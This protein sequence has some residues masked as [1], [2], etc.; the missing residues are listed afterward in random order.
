MK[1]TL[2]IFAAMTPVVAITGAAADET[3][4]SVDQAKL[5]AAVPASELLGEDVYAESGEEIGN[6]QGIRVSRSAVD[7][8]DSFVVETD[9]DTAS[10]GE[11]F[12]NEVY[13]QPA[14]VD[15]DS[16]NDRLLVNESRLRAS[17]SSTGELDDERRGMEMTDIIGAEVNLA[18]KDSF[19]TV[20]EVMI[21]DDN[22][23]IVA[24][25]VDSLDGMD[26]HRRALPLEK[27]Q[28]SDEPEVVNFSFTEAQVEQLPE[29]NLEEH[30]DNGWNMTD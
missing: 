28:V 3:Q 1:R 22:S 5:R 11:Y 14:S 15:Y 9:R 23:E 29:F 30:E 4:I 7:Q 18:D 17:A 26:K 13:V 10:R 8:V 21:S 6:L 12:A 25:V 24:V 27:A 20:E 16:G 19:G 2:M